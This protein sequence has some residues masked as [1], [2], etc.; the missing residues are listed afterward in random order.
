[1]SIDSVNGLVWV[2]GLV[3]PTIAATY[4]L[5]ITGYLPSG[6]SA[7]FSLIISMTPCINTP[8]IPSS[9]IDQI[10]YVNFPTGSYDAPA[11]TVNASCPQAMTYTNSV[12]TNNAMTTANDVTNINFINNNAGAGKLVSWQTN[13][14]LNINQYTISITANNNCVSATK[15]YILDVRS[16]CEAQ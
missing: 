12:A 7:S 1:M 3:G 11:F 4:T 9:L 10:Y 16:V 2:K 14:D 5:K 15:S 13:D 6:Q 8:I